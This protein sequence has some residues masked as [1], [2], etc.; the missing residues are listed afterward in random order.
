MT[1]SA[2]TI[3]IGGEPVAKGRPRV[4]RKGFVYTPTATRKFEGHG[5][6]AAQLAINGKPPLAAPVRADITVDLPVP[7]SWSGKRPDAALRGE[8][9]PTVRPDCDNYCKSAMDAIN[10][11]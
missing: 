10:A 7:T 11:I 6:P 3:L 8:I 4:T 1:D 9:R 5:R 2:V